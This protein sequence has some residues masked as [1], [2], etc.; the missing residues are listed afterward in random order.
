MTSFTFNT[1]SSMCAI[2]TRICFSAINPE[3]NLQNLF[4]LSICCNK[5]PLCPK[6]R[7]DHIKLH[8][9]IMWKY[10]EYKVIRL[11]KENDKIKNCPCWFCQ[12]VLC[13]TRLG[14]F[15][16]FFCISVSSSGD[17]WVDLTPAA[18]RVNWCGC[19]LGWSAVQQ[20]CAKPRRQDHFQTRTMKTRTIT[21]NNSNNEKQKQWR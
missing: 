4:T 21:K 8:D 3:E 13:C 7:S 18:A 2:C 12:N 14:R 16:G 17:C 15:F 11:I 20:W 6:I 19:G 1:I 5:I 9:G 10:P